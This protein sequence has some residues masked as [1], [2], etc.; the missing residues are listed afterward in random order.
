MSPELAEEVA[1]LAILHISEWDNFLMRAEAT[2]EPLEFVKLRKA[3]ALAMGEFQCEI[4]RAVQ[5]QHPGVVPD[6]Q[7]GWVKAK[8]AAKSRRNEE[9]G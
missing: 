4:L 6:D 5:S 3:I 9:G 1:S 2:C 8:E 7:P